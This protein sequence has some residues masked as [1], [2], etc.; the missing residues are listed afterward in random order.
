[1]DVVTVQKSSCKRRGQ[2]GMLA[3]NLPLCE[4]HFPIPPQGPRPPQGMDS[5]MRPLSRSRPGKRHYVGEFA[6]SPPDA[7]I[8]G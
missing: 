1:M 5:W 4:G 7:R 3:F 8:S 6:G 2:G